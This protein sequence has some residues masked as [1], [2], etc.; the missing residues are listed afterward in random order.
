[1]RVSDGV[2]ADLR[3]VL[4]SPTWIAAILSF[5]LALAVLMARVDLLAAQMAG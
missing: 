3:E 5:E 1:M 2:D 4:Q